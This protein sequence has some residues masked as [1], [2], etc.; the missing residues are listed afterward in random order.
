MQKNHAPSVAPGTPPLKAPRQIDH[1][2]LALRGRLGALILHAT[3]DP[4]ETTSKARATFLKGFLQEADP[5]GDLPQDERLRR[6]EY[7]RRAHFARMAYRSAQTRR[8]RSL[9]KNAASA[10]KER[11]AAEEVG[12]GAATTSDG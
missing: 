8:Q 4:R 11:L 12:D 5:S 6:A 10:F 9:K 7:L 1:E 3:H 2:S